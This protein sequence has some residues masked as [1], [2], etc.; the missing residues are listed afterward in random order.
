MGPCS[1]FGLTLYRTTSHVGQDADSAWFPPISLP[2]RQVSAYTALIRPS[3]Q[4]Q[5]FP[6]I[7]GSTFNATPTATPS[8]EKLRCYCGGR[9]R[10]PLPGYD[11]TEANG[12]ELT[13]GEREYREKNGA[14]WISKNEIT[15]CTGRSKQNAIRT[16]LLQQK[17][18]ALLEG[19]R[20]SDIPQP[21]L[22]QELVDALHYDD[23]NR[24]ENRKAEEEARYQGTILEPT[25]SE[26]ASFIV[27]PLDNT[28]LG[29]S[30]LEDTQGMRAF[31]HRD[32][33][34]KATHGLSCCSNTGP[35]MSDIGR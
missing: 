15:N 19:S 30:I 20:V 26:D 8:V 4:V 29:D 2:G 25:I 18:R 24:E 14:R 28:I 7:Q 34:G 3:G 32:E 1:E 13:R 33:G 35:L 5:I 12:V 31:F 23:L 27:T 16:E 9:T 6:V 10:Y 17:R 21:E 22:P 11:E